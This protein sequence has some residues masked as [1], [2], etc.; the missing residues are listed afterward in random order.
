MGACAV[1]FAY[2]VH[3]D[4]GNRCVGVRVDKRNYSLSQPL[5]NGQTVEIIT[6]PRAKPNANWLNYVVSAKKARSA[7]RHYLKRQQTE[8]ATDMGFT[9]YV[10]HWGRSNTTIFQR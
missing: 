8:D 4:V 1:D 9:Y 3:S 5:Q 7:I 10:M 2:A 6:S